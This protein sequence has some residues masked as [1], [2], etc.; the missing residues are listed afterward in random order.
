MEGLDFL[1]EDGFFCGDGFV[2]E[3]VV[4]C[5][6]VVGGDDEL[7]GFVVEFVG[8][9]VDGGVDGVFFVVFDGCFFGGNELCLK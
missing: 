4:G 6:G 1:G 8:V 5:G 2:C 7:V 3:D 9:G